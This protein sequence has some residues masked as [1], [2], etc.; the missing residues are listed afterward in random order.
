MTPLTA[1]CIALTLALIGLAS[2]W[3]LPLTGP[4]CAAALAWLMMGD[5]HG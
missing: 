1:N 4:L 3:G 5:D 2:L